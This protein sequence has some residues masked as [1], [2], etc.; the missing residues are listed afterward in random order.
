M[1][2]FVYMLCSTAL[3]V[4]LLPVF[5]LFALRKKHR[6]RMP[7]R[8]G[9][10][11]ADQMACLPPTAG[12]TFWLHALSVGE[13]TSALPLVRALRE[14]YPEARL[15]FSTTTVAGG[16][17]ARTLLAPFVDAL[18]AAPLDLGPVVPFFLAT[19]KPDLFV[20]VETDFWPHWLHCLTRR[21]IPSVLVNGRISARSFAR[22]RRLALFFRPMFDAFTLLSMQTG[23]DAAKMTALGIAPEKV[24]TLGNLKFDTSQAPPTGEHEAAVSLRK[25]RYGFAAASPLWICGSTHRGEEE[26][27]FAVYQRLRA[28]IAD[29]QVLLAPRNVERAEEIAALGRRLGLPCRRWSCERAGH[30]PVLLLDTIGELA[31]CYAMADVVFIGGSLV[32][33]GG[34]NPIEP[35]AACAPVL[36]GPHMEDFAEIAEELIRSGGA[37]RV[38][39]SAALQTTLRNILTDPSRRQAM[40]G[41]ALAC[42]QTNRGVV[43]KHLEALSR[44]LADTPARQRGWSG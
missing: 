5:P 25:E 18:I 14:S 29:L 41:A 11:L 40:A 2:S 36:F 37:C 6:G 43:R 9:L 26:L 27:L 39:S 8:L 33:E 42:V 30:G 24:V 34:H 19:I 7:K 16:E 38:A 17:V 15:V 10:G 28:E 44:L 22:Y 3:A 31:G 21:G 23:A 4:L 20:L 13:T 35:A 1:M 12:P 32:A